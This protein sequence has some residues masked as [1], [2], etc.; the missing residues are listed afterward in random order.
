[1]IKSRRTSS[2]NEK[3][4]QR[5]YSQE[6]LVILGTVLLDQIPENVNEYVAID[7]PQIE[8]F[9]LN[10]PE[11]DDDY[12][13]DDGNYD[14]DV[15]NDEHPVR[16]IMTRAQ[17]LDRRHALKYCFS[18]LYGSP[19]EEAWK[20]LDLISALCATLAI[21]YNSRSRVKG[22][23]KVLLE[24][25]NHNPKKTIQRKM[26]IV[27]NSD[28]AKIIYDDLEHDIST[29]MTTFM[30]STWLQ[31]EGKQP[32]SWSA[33]ENFKIKGSEIIVTS[34]RTTKKSGKLDPTLPWSQARNATFTQFKEMLRLGESPENH[35][36][37]VDPPFP[38]LVG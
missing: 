19:P 34:K 2:A 33:V 13:N 35:P 1:V 28:E 24:N 31:S 17:A 6:E 32:V 29:S 14:K 12:R 9:V 8:I 15:G 10:T 22:F 27:E 36:D 4:W 16:K 38:P 25:P 3:Y 18:Y 21:P 23:L 37:R 20:E 11:D 26:I 30:L 5:F 7:D